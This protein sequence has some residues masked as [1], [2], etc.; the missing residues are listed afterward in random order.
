MSELR[1]C[2]QRGSHWSMA[3][4]L[5]TLVL[6]APLLAHDARPV[7]VSITETPAD[8]FA[9]V[10]SA[11]PTVDADNQP[12]LV[13]PPHC[14]ALADAPLVRH[15]AGG[16]A[17]H[18]LALAYPRFN[19]SLAT[20]YRLV[21]AE[22]RQSAAMLAP[23]QAQWTVPAASTASSVALD[24]LL[25]GID[26]IIGG[27]DHLLFVLGLLVI[28]R[29]PRRILLTV[30]GFTLAHSITLSLSSLGLLQIP[31]V[32]V[33]AAI[34]LSI[35]LLAYEISRPHQDSLTWRFPLL[36]AF[37]VG[38]LH[39][40][41]FASALGEIG[42]ARD[43]VLVSLLFFNLGVEAGQVLFIVIVLGLVY[44]LQRLLPVSLPRPDQGRPGG[45]GGATR[46]AD[47][48]AAYIIGI[49]SAYWLIERL[50]QF[51]L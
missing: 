43:E 12:Q 37:G 42:F 8:V 10:V 46:R 50:A 34:A 31:I 15:C 2:T 29:T 9:V 17:G 36:V 22:G 27:L 41:G 51:M 21:T 11:P 48:L 13:W 6:C 23:S 24:Y 5:F 7:A 3:R 18:A 49:P 28:A 32:P 33:E 20:Y 19:P 16:L 26:H 38:L 4:L 39:G 45:S 25:L 44:G 14:A 30:T 1:R 47:L 40:L 35:L